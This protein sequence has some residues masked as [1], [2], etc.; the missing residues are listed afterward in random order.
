MATA[1]FDPAIPA[2]KQSQTYPLDR[3]TTGIGRVSLVLIQF[4]VPNSNYVL[5]R[6]FQKELYNFESL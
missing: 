3:T 4:H 5:Y 2:S 6:V 1:G